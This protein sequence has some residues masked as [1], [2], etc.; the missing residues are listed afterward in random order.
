MHIPTCPCQLFQWSAQAHLVVVSPTYSKLFYKVLLTRCV[1]SMSARCWLLHVVKSITVPKWCPKMDYHAFP[2][3]IRACWF[4]IIRLHDDFSL[5]VERYWTIFLAR[6]LKTGVSSAQNKWDAVFQPLPHVASF[7][8]P[9][10]LPLFHF[11][12]SHKKNCHLSNLKGKMPPT[13]EFT[14]PVMGNDLTED[15]NIQSQHDHRVSRMCTADNSHVP[16]T[17]CHILLFLKM[18]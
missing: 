1:V 4:R 16:G 13:D 6:G 8:L 15:E 3:S 10:F 17:T 7:S 9:Y 12:L 11:I 2:N 14:H 18:I 5:F